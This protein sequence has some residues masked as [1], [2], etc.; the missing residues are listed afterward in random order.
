VKEEEHVD[1]QIRRT[2][3]RKSRSIFDDILRTEEEREFPSDD[4]ECM[5]EHDSER[6]FEYLLTKNPIVE[7]LGRDENHHQEEALTY[8]DTLKPMLR[9]AAGALEQRGEVRFRRYQKGSQIVWVV[10][11][12]RRRARFLDR[13]ISDFIAFLKRAFNAA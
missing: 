3:K 12:D 1:I 4:H 8:E 2:G 9:D 5:F 6:T 10:Q 7:R 13:I 11:V